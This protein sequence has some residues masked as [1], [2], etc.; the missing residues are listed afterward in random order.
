M[1]NKSFLNLLFGVVSIKVIG[2]ISGFYLTY[3][4]ASKFSIEESGRFFTELSIIT[5]FIMIISLGLPSYCVKKVSELKYRQKINSANSLITYS[6]ISVCMAGIIIIINNFIFNIVDN[7]MAFSLIPLSLIALMSSYIQ[8]SKKPRISMLFTGVARNLVF[9]ILLLMVSIERYSELSLLFFITSLICCISSFCFWSK[10]G[11]T[12]VIKE[13][14]HFLFT[15]SILKSSSFFWGISFLTVLSSQL[16]QFLI[17]T[18]AGYSEASGYAVAVRIA[19]VSSIVLVAINRIIAPNIAEFYYKKN[20]L[21]L[22]KEINRSTFITFFLSTIYFFIIAIFSDV[23][24]SFFGHEYLFAKSS[25]VLMMLG[26][27][28]NSSFGS[29]G[30]ILQMTGYSRVQQRNTLISIVTSVFVG[31]IA[32]PVF[33]LLGAALMFSSYLALVNL[34]SW[35]DVRVRLGINTLKVY[36]FY[37]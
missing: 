31:L 20:Q 8:A 27:W 11:G 19:G 18:M 26:Q 25:L 9:V 16:P 37:K 2:A 23:I 21:E 28:L 24:L 1:S 7:K 15:K 34:L 12:F 3:L 36:K 22:E 17:G 5:I 14:S 6:G 13:R 4:I 10:L 33:G 32:I 30:T 29:V 35:N